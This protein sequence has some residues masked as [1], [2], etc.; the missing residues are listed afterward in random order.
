MAGAKGGKIWRKR[1]DR[2]CE[3]EDSIEV[4]RTI[5]CQLRNVLNSKISDKKQ[6]Q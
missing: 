6:K 2:A 1:E 4:R 5:P 3:G